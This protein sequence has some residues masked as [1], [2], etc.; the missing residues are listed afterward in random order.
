MTTVYHFSLWL[1]LQLGE[2]EI[3]MEKFTFC[4]KQTI[5]LWSPTVSLS[6]KRVRSCIVY[7]HWSD[8][9]VGEQFDDVVSESN[10]SDEIEEWK[11]TVAITS[12]YT[13]DTA[14]LYVK[15][16]LNYS[17]VWYW[18]QHS[19]CDKASD[20]LL[21]CCLLSEIFWSFYHI[22]TSKSLARRSVDSGK[23]GRGTV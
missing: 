3:T 19:E 7:I 5:N 18:W 2:F 8:T 4:Q 6:I 12:P 23:G 17:S 16:T 20:K 21:F 15:S 11:K 9:P 1:L 14:E 10:W 13:M 22:T